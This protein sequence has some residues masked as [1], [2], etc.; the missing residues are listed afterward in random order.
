VVF[1]LGV[2]FAG[3][4]MASPLMDPSPDIESAEPLDDGPDRAMPTIPPDDSLLEDEREEARARRCA[5]R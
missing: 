2:L 1:V 3:S 4:V 5:C